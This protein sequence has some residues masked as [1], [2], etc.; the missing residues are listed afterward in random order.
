M[1]P[2]GFVLW[3]ILVKHSFMHYLQDVIY[4]VVRVGRSIINTKDTLTFN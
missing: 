3:H 2:G 4:T 1:L